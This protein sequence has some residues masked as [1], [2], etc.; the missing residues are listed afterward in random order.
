[1]TQ[2]SCINDP[3]KTLKMQTFKVLLGAALPQVGELSCDKF[4]GLFHY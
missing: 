3:D 2:C 4:D 1:M